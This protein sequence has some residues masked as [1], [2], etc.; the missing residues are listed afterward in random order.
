MAYSLDEAKLLLQTTELTQQA[1][2]NLVKQI[3]V[4]AS[5]TTTIFYG[6][7]LPDGANAS[8]VIG[9]MVAAGDDTCYATLTG[10]ATP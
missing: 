7:N 9:K 3:S 5:G 10:T 8:A 1:L 4:E 6:G 2:I